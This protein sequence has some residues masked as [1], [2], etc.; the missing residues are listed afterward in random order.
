MHWLEE[1]YIN[2]E[3]VATRLYGRRSRLHTRQLHDRL[4]G[5]FPFQNWEKDRLEEIRRNILHQLA[6]IRAEP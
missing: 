5:R 2:L 4:R 3:Y 6:T 1:P